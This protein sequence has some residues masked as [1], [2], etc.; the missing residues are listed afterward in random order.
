MRTRQ[1]ENC[2]N[3]HITKSFSQFL[4]RIHPHTHF[5]LLNAG[6]SYLFGHP[7]RPIHF[8]TILDTKGR[9]LSPVST[10]T[11]RYPMTTWLTRTQRPPHDIKHMFWECLSKSSHPNHSKGH[12]HYLCQVW[13][14]HQSSQTRLVIPRTTT[15]P[16]SHRKGLILR[17][18]GKGYVY[19]AGIHP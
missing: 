3:N 13:G 2:N 11:S 4:L 10:K 5:F 8:R 6:S 1:W 9:I 18:Y 19:I 16:P 17:V 7:C 15:H 14:T 12:L